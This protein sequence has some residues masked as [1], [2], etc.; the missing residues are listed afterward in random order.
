MAALLDVRTRAA[1]RV[2]VRLL[3]RV[4]NLAPSRRPADRE[5]A[6]E[7][8]DPERARRADRIAVRAARGTLGTIQF[9]LPARPSG[10]ACR[11]WCRRSWTR[12]CC[13]MRRLRGIVAGD[14]ERV[15]AFVRRG[16]RPDGEEGIDDDPGD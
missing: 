2:T 5:L 1:P 14:V 8:L 16:A 9:F 15:R 7:R 10:C 11:S 4:E 6:G 12:C 13:T 3:A